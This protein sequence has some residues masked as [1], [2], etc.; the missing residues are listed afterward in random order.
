MAASEK[1]VSD[2]ERLARVETKV[3]HGERLARVET[4]VEHIEQQ[5]TELRQ[6][7][8]DLVAKVG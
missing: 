6:A 8:R 4:K 3:E 7:L 1:E 5:L 2:G